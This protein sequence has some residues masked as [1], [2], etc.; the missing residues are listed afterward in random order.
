[1]KHHSE[2]SQ[3]YHLFIYREKGCSIGPLGAHFDTYRN[4]KKIYGDVSKYRDARN[5]IY[6]FKY[7]D[8]FEH[9]IWHQFLYRTFPCIRISIC[10]MF[11]GLPLPKNTQKGTPHWGRG[12]PF[13]HF[14][15]GRWFFT[16]LYNTKKDPTQD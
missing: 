7:A 8:L 12:V 14:S 3:N 16:I 10:K 11:F 6:N 4:L 9:R 1:M 13:W 2:M 5:L 15:F